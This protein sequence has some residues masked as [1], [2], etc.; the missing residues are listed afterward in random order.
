[1]NPRLAGALLAIVLLLPGCSRRNRAVEVDPGAFSWTTVQGDLRRAGT[2]RESVPGNPTVAWTVDIGRGLKSQPVVRQGVLLVA[3]SNR[4]VAAYSA[5]TGDRFWEQRPNASISGG[6]VWR[7]D[8]LWL[9]TETL[10]GRAMALQLTKGD[11]FWERDVGPAS[12]PPLL[13]GPRLYVA[14]DDG[15]V[16]ALDAAT[17]EPAWRTRLPGGV[18]GTP[19][20]HGRSIVAVAARDT[21]YVLDPAEGDITGRIAIPSAASALPALRGDLLVLPLRGGG[22]AAVDLALGEVRWSA[23]VGADILATPVIAEDG[24]VYVLTTSAEVWRVAPD[25]REPVRIAE[26]GGAARASLTLV[27]GGLLV[28]R[29]DGAL[30][31]LDRSGREQ[32]R[33]DLEGSIFAPVAVA[34][35]AIFVPLLDGRLSKLE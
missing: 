30:F 9:A 25:A 13:V 15:S 27:D 19:V 31:F 10:S 22:L 3:A 5:R 6:V 34:E 33:R 26:L 12:H 8:T 29:L 24:T 11:D 14:T 35:Q 20:P 17:G 16:S 1:L 7:S 4:L 21:I 18:G 23:E 28:G 2:E 32:W